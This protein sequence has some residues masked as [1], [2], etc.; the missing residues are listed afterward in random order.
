VTGTAQAALT[1]IFISLIVLGLMQITD[2]EDH[3]SILIRRICL[4]ARH[5]V[6]RV[7][8]L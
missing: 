7:G 2:L 4:C 6:C 8:I 5:H 1:I 3:N